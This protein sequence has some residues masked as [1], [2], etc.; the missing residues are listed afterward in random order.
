MAGEGK[1]CY[2]HNDGR[3]CYK[4]GGNGSL[5]YKV[6]GQK[7][8]DITL[9]IVATQPQVGPIDSCGNIHNVL[10]NPSGQFT[11]GAGSFVVTGSSPGQADCKI[12][13]STKPASVS[14]SCTTE[15]EG[16]AYPD[17]N[18]PMSFEVI[19]NQVGVVGVKRTQKS[20]SNVARGSF[21]VTVTVGSDGKMTGVS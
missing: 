18:P 16:C 8:G 17:E 12:T 5:V 4:G 15:S 20:V 13:V 7:T 11:Q 14:V 3:L 6:G 9:E 2:K 10:I 19:A 21:T 1:L